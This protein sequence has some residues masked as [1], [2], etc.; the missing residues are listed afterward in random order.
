MGV[1][2]AGDLILSTCRSGFACTW[3][4][5][6]TARAPLRHSSPGETLSFTSFCGKYSLL[7]RFRDRFKL[8]RLRQ[9]NLNPRF[10]WLWDNLQRIPCVRTEELKGSGWMVL[11]FDLFYKSIHWTQ[12]EGTS[13][14]KLCYNTGQVILITCIEMMTHKSI[15]SHIWWSRAKR[16][17]HF[18]G[19]AK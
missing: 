10:V 6:R 12:L 9:V 18:A 3:A 4:P 15:G 11:N 7:M 5:L 2:T 13:Y 17:V 19:C 14:R 8:R 1:S 16:T